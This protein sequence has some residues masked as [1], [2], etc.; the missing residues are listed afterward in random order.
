RPGFA[1]NPTNCDPFTVAARL[2]GDEGASVSPSA[3]FQAANCTDLDFE[4]RLSLRLSGSSKRRGHPGVHAVIKA[5][6]DEANIGRTVVT[7][8]PNLILDNAH[9]RLPCTRVQFDREACPESTKIGTAQ[10]TTPLLDAPLEGPVYLRS[11]P[12]HGLPDV[13]VSLKGAIDIQLVGKIDSQ[14]GG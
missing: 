7:M 10:A 12:S 2:G 1:L 5:G 13:V 3:R 4:P 8:P 9:V 6:H 11:N 14:G